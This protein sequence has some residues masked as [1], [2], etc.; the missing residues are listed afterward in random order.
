[1]EVPLSPL[2]FARRTRRLYRDRE[3]VVDVATGVMAFGGSGWIEFDSMI[4]VRPS[5]GNRTRSVDDADVQRR[6]VSTVE[7]LVR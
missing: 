1:M 5:Q 7:K 6:I 4:N 3:A 2:E